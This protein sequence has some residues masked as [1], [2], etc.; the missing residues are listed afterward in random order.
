MPLSWEETACPERAF[1]KMP[2][3]VL[4]SRAPRSGAIR[5][6]SPDQGIRGLSQPP[7]ERMAGTN[8]RTN[9]G[10]NPSSAVG[11]AT[12]LV[13]RYPGL[14]PAPWAGSGARSCASEL[15]SSHDRGGESV[16]ALFDGARR[17]V[18]EP[19]H[20]RVRPKVRDQRSDR[21]PAGRVEGRRGDRQS[22]RAGD[23]R[24]ERR[25]APRAASW[26]AWPGDADAIAP[27]GSGGAA[28]P[29]RS[30]T[31]VPATSGRGALGEVRYLVAACAAG[32]VEQAAVGVHPLGGAEQVEQ[33]V[34]RAV[35]VGAPERQGWR[36]GVNHPNPTTRP[37]VR[38][39]NPKGG[40][41]A[42]L[43]Q[44]LGRTY[45]H[46]RLAQAS[47]HPLHGARAEPNEGSRVFYGRLSP[48]AIDGSALTE[49]GTIFEAY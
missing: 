23:G 32:A 42:E 21:L 43:E 24:T 12:S 38:D 30:R 46:T 13:E 9:P 37:L 35:A 26:G 36:H 22:V 7:R 8:P 47:R 20:D 2:P 31:I 34:G 18:L 29:P 40:K 16:V 39:T 17:V 33:D 3:G 28:S 49:P 5:R 25:S 1:S 44:C 4:R 11:P 27:V 14:G 10:T 6:R 15:V 19:A 45:R 41:R 48:A